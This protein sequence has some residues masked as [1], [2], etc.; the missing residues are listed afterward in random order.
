MGQIDWKHWSA[1]KEVRIS[2]AVALSLNIDPDDLEWDDYDE[3]FNQGKDFDKRLRLLKSGASDRAHFTACT[4]DMTYSWA[5]CIRLIE[6]GVWFEMNE[7]ALPEGFPRPVRPVIKRYIEL[8]ENVPIPFGDLALKMAEAMWPDRGETDDRMDFGVALVNLE[9]ELRGAAESGTLTVRNAS[10]LKK[11]TFIAGAALKRTVVL[12]R[13]DLAPFLKERGGIDLRLL[14]HGTGPDYWTIENASNAIAEQLSWHK[15]SREALVRQMISAAQAGDLIVR[16]PQSSLPDRPTVVR[17]YYELLTPEDVNAWLGR[18]SAPYRWTLKS[19]YTAA[20][21]EQI[22][23]ASVWWGLANISVDE[24]AMLLSGA[25]PHDPHADPMSTTHEDGTGP[26]DYA[27][28]RR[29]F[30][31]VAGDGVKRSLGL[32]LAVAEERGLRYH[33]WIGE[34]LGARG[35]S[36]KKVLELVAKGKAAQR[37]DTELDTKPA[38]MVS[39]QVSAIE[40]V[41]TKKALTDQYAGR[42]PSVVAD[43]ADASKNGLAACAKAGARGWKELS[44]IEWARTRGKLKEPNAAA[45]LS[46]VMRQL[47][48]RQHRMGD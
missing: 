3:S 4:L 40:A 6:A 15:G 33:S 47:P 23:E 13:E 18:Q 34:W 30:E 20:W 42:W 27:I 12:P 19:G 37:V 5:C 7:L 46:S 25:N 10:T 16:D 45:E 21:F 24:A 29:V 8:P 9:G 32:W 41:L 22:Y 28:L 2:E 26:K 48:R 14:P 35:E 43:L 1:L 39:D 31:D 36:V 11:E 17:P 38:N 44:A